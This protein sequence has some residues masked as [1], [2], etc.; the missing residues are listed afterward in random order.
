[1]VWQ[2]DFE[3]TLSSSLSYTASRELQADAAVQREME[4]P[5]NG[6]RID[7]LVKTKSPQLVQQSSSITEQELRATD[8]P[9]PLAQK[10]MRGGVYVPNRQSMKCSR[11]T[12]AYRRHLRTEVGGK[13]RRHETCARSRISGGIRTLPCV[14]CGRTQWIEAAHTGLRGL[15]PEILRLLG[16]SVMWSASPNG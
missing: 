5:I 11:R 7:T 12:C 8:M 3:C 2:R 1:M 6:V 16:D 10:L 13:S 4:E 14:V 15:G 9:Y